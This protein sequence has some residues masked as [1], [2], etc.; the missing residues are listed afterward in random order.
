[1]H[2]TTVFTIDTMLVLPFPLQAD[3]FTS[4]SRKILHPGAVHITVD[5]FNHVSYQNQTIIITQRNGTVTE[6]P[7]INKFH[8]SNRLVNDSVFR[9]S[10]PGHYHGYGEGNP[11]ITV[12]LLS[13]YEGR[14]LGTQ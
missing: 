9:F 5:V 1:M 8:L 6:F 10:A 12:K 2:S 4:H 14:V 11:A 13:T 7:G 3:A